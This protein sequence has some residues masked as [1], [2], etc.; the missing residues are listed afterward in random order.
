LIRERWYVIKVIILCG[1]LGTRLREQTEFIPKPMIMIGNR[2]MLWHI[3]KIYYHQGFREFILPL[4]YK[5]D[6]IKE[7]FINYRWKTRDLMIDDEK[8]I[9]NGAPSEKWK[10][11][12]VDTGINT[13]TARRVYLVKH[14]I[15]DDEQFMLTYG[16]GVA[17][18][19]LN[20]LLAIHKEKGKLAT[21]SGSRPFHRFGIINEKDNI[22]THFSEK[23]QMK[24]WVNAG[25]MVFDNKA[26]DYFTESNTMFETDV[27]PRLARDNQV[28][29][30]FHNGSWYFMDTQ[31]DCE[32]INEE[33]EKDPVWKVWKD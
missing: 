32:I 1:G 23:P 11:H 10:I 28:S 19:D 30:Y 6:M 21:V 13:L 27:M 4:G 7:Y 33:W 12:F 20:G 29:V 8:I 14:L 17:D 9:Y 25:F 18:I 3:M 31:R 22:I 16:D 26:L 2:P 5:G 24:D 15:K